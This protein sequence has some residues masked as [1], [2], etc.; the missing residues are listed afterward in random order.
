MFT[1]GLEFALEPAADNVHRNAAVGQ[2]V[3]GRQL[4][5][6]QGGL[7]RPGQDRG[8]HFERGRRSQQRVTEGHRFMLILRTVAGREANLRQGIFKPRRLGQLRQLAVVVD[9]PVGALLNL[10]DHQPTADVRHP[11]GEFDGLLTHWHDL[12]MLGCAKG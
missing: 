12:G 4:F 11:V 7:P 2:L 6:R 5:R 8:N 1:N 9:A 10:A 3:D